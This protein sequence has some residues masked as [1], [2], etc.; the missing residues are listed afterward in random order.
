MQVAQSM[1]GGLELTVPEPVEVTESERLCS[2]KVAVT[3][4]A[5]VNVTRHVPVPEQSPPQPVK[6]EPFAGLAVSVTCVPLAKFTEQAAP[7]SIP[8]GDEVTVPDPAPDLVT[9]SGLGART[10]IVSVEETEGCAEPPS[11]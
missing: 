5:A 10:D 3:F 2:E 7:Q 11:R 4:L 9:V 6:N 1:P 8:A